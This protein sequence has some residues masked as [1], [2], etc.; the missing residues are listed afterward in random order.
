[1]PAEQHYYA[2]VPYRAIFRILTFLSLKP[3]DVFVDL[4]CGKGR[5]VCC[6]ATY[7]IAEAIGIEYVRESLRLGAAQ[8][9]TS[10]PK[11]STGI[12]IMLEG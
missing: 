4:G 6:A 7:D 8:C 12:D 2:T 11:E 9:A 10:A 5:V 1:M 3:S